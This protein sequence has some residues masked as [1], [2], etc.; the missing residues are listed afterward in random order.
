MGLS[1]FLLYSLID[2]ID[3]MNVMIRSGL[4]YIEVYN[5]RDIHTIKL[6]VIF[7]YKFFVILN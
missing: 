6:N 4:H 2:T 5:E 7:I 3:L 1:V